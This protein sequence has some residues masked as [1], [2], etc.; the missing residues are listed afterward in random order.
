M[1]RI[2]LVD[3]GSN[4]IRLVIFEYSE[5]TG[6]QE[7]QNIKTPA[8]L[9][10]YLDRDKVMAQEG[11]EVLCSTLQSFQQVAAKFHVEALYPVATAAVRQSKNI[12]EIISYVKEQTNITMQIVT[13]KEEA[14]YGYYA[15]VHTLNFS[16]GVT[17][18]IGGGSTEVTYFED[19]ELKFSHSFPF[20]VVTLQKLFFEN[21]KHNDDKAVSQ[22]RAFIKEQ[23][24]S[25]KWLAKRKVPIIAIG[26][27]ARNIA[28]IHQ[29]LVEYPI[30]G[31]HGYSMKEEDI[32]VV[33]KK[34][35][36][37]TMDDL[38]DLD[39]LS[40][41]RRDIIIPS[42]LLF[43]E[44]Y[45]EVEAT[46]F[47]FSRKGL[48]EGVIMS[49]LEKEYKHPFDKHEVFKES[50]RNLAYSY[51]IG[52]QEA[53]QRQ[54]L[55]EMLYYELE[56]NDLIDGNKLDKKLLLQSAYLFYL[57]SYI[58]SDA[59][60]QHTYYIISNSSLN[61]VSHRNRVKLA[62]LSSYKNKTLLKFFADETGWF[63]EAEKAKIQLLGSILKFAYALNS[64]NTS[65]VNSLYLEK[66]KDR[67]N[68]VIMYKGDP[69]AEEYQAERQKK[70][71][72]K[73]VKAKIHITFTEN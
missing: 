44:L 50:L 24:Q 31:V 49:I 63:T 54:R 56:K 17:V 5:S 11:I 29:S 19:K 30:A 7:L 58:D 60:S 40:R 9:Y 15:V 36:S 48:R 12:E 26:G 4:T 23:L 20:G 62:L 71:L 6:L 8:R 43:K 45:E 66:H 47:V 70:H 65:V 3:I 35:M 22:A 51:N 28:R 59:A 61:G 52:R 57:G 53:L 72:E 42:T 46:E 33:Y 73:I 18:D 32:S 64:S 67:Y 41:D 2:G 27:S 1:R 38:E 13:E 25:L 37:S 14:F 10:Q 34:L 21:K 69:I 39:G 68:L 55:A 16:D